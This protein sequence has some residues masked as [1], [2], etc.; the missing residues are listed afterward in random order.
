MNVRSYANLVARTQVAEA[1]RVGTLTRLKQNRVNHV[2]ISQHVQQKLDECTPFAGKVFFI[3]DGVDPLGF[4]RL[5]SIPNGGPPFHPNCKHVIIPFVVAFKS[6]ANIAEAQASS[7]QIPRALQGKT[8][9][10]VRE[11]VAAMSD[12]Q[13]KQIA[14]EGFSDVAA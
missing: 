10:E 1:H 3:G 9:S 14:A 12:A 6:G 7:A 4:P 2:K 5:T 11:Q 8:G 13:L